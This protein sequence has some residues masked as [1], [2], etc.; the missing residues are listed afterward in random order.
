M[1]AKF[2]YYLSLVHR[3]EHTVDAINEDVT[4]VY[5]R[6]RQ[7]PHHLIQLLPGKAHFPPIRQAAQWRHHRSDIQTYF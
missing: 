3:A 4:R 6:N 2:I 1:Q 7:E 5:A